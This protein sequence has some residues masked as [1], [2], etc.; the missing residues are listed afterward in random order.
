MRIVHKDLKKGEIKVAVETADDLWQL[1][2]IV[3]KGDS[4]SGRTFRKI[5]VGSSENAKTVR[6]PVFLKIEVEK[7]DF[8]KSANTLRILGV[9]R[10]GTE[11]V[12]MG[13]H[14]SFGVEPDTQI[15]I[16]KNHWLKFQ[17]D[18]IEEACKK[19]SNTL[20]LVLDRDVATFALLKNYG[21]DIISD[22][23]GEVQRK[24]DTA[25]VRSDFFAE[26]ASLLKEYVERYS[27]EIVI[28]ASPGFWKDEFKKRLPSDFPKKIVYAVCNDSGAKGVDEVLKRDEVKVVLREDRTSK[29][30]LLVEQLLTEISKGKLAAYGFD[31]VK[32]AVDA[33]AVKLLLV[34]DLFIHSEKHNYLVTDEIM[35][36]A[37]ASNADVFIISSENEAGRKLDG[38]GG[39]GAVL[40]FEFQ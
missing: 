25:S 37:E 33:G 4:V 11:D 34:T 31:E 10:E 13:E 40:R 36:N 24:G 26:V 5:K 29:E 28:V 20:I 15:A 2:H 18:K 17:L 30:T 19:R 27:I 9:V 21:F 1:S 8:T 16:Q 23:K 38:L 32:K 6:K 39:I 35:R 7:V 12:P 3:E 22:L 14:H